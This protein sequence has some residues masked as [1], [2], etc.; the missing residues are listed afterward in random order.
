MVRVTI[1]IVPH[2]N[3]EEAYKV[4]EINIVNDLSGTLDKGN[5]IYKLDADNII[6]EGKYKGFNRSEGV[7]PLVKKVL[8]K[9]INQYK[10]DKNK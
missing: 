3:D 4:S 2:G 7:L 9:A 8:T 1:E 5:Y 10:K 6:I